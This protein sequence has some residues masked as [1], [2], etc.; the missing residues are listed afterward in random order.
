M[1]RGTWFDRKSKRVHGDFITGVIAEV[2]YQPRGGRRRKGEKPTSYVQFTDNF[3]RSL[4][5]GNLINVDLELL[6]NWSSPTA[7]LLFRH[8]N[9]VWHSGRKPFHYERDLKEIAC[10][11]LHMT[12]GKN[13]KENFSNVLREMERRHYLAAMTQEQRFEMIRRGVWRVSFDLHPDHVFKP[14]AVRENVP[15]TAATEARE[16]IAA[17]ARERFG[18]QAY[19]PRDHELSHAETLIAEFGREAVLRVTPSVVER[20]KQ[21]SRGDL[22][23]GFAAPYFRMELA[24]KAAGRGLRERIAAT[25]T[26]THVDQTRIA[27]E[28]RQRQQQHAALLT[29]WHNATEPERSTYRAQALQK[30]PS[31]TARR[32]ILNSS[33][34]EPVHDVLQELDLARR[35]GVTAA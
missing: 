28:G 12:A 19:E 11:H 20:V 3:H 24:A 21:Q 35:R 8:L 9:K 6:A 4:T 23:F 18:N 33:F 15:S 2:C 5:D 26:L 7:A 17:Y 32:R 13:L 25:S 1:F 31:E 22:Y 29:A 30:A 16:I 27:E 34:D 10:G 14:K